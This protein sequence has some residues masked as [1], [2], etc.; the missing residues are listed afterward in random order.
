[1]IEREDFFQVTITR[2]MAIVSV[3]GRKMRNM[4]GVAGS[5]SYF[6]DMELF[7][8]RVTGEIF[9]TLAGERINVEMISQ[10]ASEIN[11]SCGLCPI[12][13]NLSW[14]AKLSYYSFVVRGTD[15]LTAMN[16]VH[17]KVLRIPSHSDEPGNSLIPGKGDFKLW[18][19][20]ASLTRVPCDA[21]Q[22]LGCFSRTI[23]FLEIHAIITV[24][25]G[26]RESR[27]MEGKSG[28]WNCLPFELGQTTAS[29]TRVQ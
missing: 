28:R 15:A 2:N 10:G 26:T 12:N 27:C 19:S 20:R 24:C 9:S 8:R 21:K 7:L 16:C 18:Q 3:V 13:P 14:H 22:V 5:L 4:V 11:I 1:M 17:E 6:Y 25:F 29:D 23:H